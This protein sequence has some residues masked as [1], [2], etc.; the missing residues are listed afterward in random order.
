MGSS[1]GAGRVQELV[2]STSSIRYVV[3]ILALCSS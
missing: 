2:I 1:A 3:L